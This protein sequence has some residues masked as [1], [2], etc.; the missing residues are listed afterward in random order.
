MLTIKKSQN[1]FV[2]FGSFCFI[3]KLVYYN[4][5]IGLLN[6]LQVRVDDLGIR[7]LF[8]TS[9]VVLLNIMHGLHL[10]SLE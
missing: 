8:N 7:H 6:S 5:F 4:L 10:I 2:Y 9:R 3:F 1:T